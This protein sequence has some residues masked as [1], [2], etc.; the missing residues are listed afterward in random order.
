MSCVERPG[1][2]FAEVDK[3]RDRQD[4]PDGKEAFD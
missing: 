2:D 3:G 4:Y 1:G